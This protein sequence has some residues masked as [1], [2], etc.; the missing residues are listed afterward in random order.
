MSKVKLT[1]DQMERLAP[2]EKQLSKFTFKPKNSGYLSHMERE[3][4]AQV[5]YEVDG[6]KHT[7]RSCS[8]DWIRRVNYWYQNTKTES[9]KV[10]IIEI[11]KPVEAEKEVVNKKSAGRPKAVKK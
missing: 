6:Q 10:N 8:M 11:I 4:V 5:S 9:V 3:V 1:K 2:L 7:C